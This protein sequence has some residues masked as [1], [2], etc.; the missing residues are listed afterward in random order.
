MSKRGS[1]ERPERGNGPAEE[2]ADEQRNAH[3]SARERGAYPA[4]K[5]GP[6]A[7][8]R[9]AGSQKEVRCTLSKVAIEGS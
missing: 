3:S 5:M 2:E 8:R 9:E 7:Q 1:V 4:R 6:P